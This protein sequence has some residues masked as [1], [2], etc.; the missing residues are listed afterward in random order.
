M[1]AHEPAG[2]PRY[3]QSRLLVKVA[4][5]AARRFYPPSPVGGS[6]AEASMRL[7]SASHA[8]K[9]TS[10]TSSIA[11]NATSIAAYARLR[12]QSAHASNSL[13]LRERS[14]GRYWL[15]LPP[16]SAGHRRLSGRYVCA[17]WGQALDA[18]RR[19]RPAARS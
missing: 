3:P 11:D 6:L 14:A 2:F 8:S 18:N 9:G 5:A 4:M 13:M 16:V 15:G 19:R 1:R 12:A 17:I 10:A 7:S